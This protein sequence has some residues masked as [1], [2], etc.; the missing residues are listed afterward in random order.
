MVRHARSECSHQ[1]NHQSCREKHQSGLSCP[2]IRRSVEQNNARPDDGDHD[3]DANK[4][5]GPVPHFTSVSATIVAVM[6]PIMSRF[7]KEIRRYDPRAAA[8]PPPLQGA[9]KK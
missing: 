4:Q 7:A 6:T 3:A 8:A 1:G 5:K 9:E 2:F